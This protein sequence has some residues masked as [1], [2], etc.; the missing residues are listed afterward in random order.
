MI[1]RLRP[2]LDRLGRTG[3]RRPAVGVVAADADA[4][5]VALHDGAAAAATALQR[6]DVAEARRALAAI[7]QAVAAAETSD[8]RVR[9]AAALATRGHP[10]AAAAMLA[11]DRPT[12]ARAALAHAR[13]SAAGADGATACA[14][15]AEAFGRFPTPA[16]GVAYATALA[17]ELDYAGAFALLDR[18]IAADPR[19]SLRAARVRLLERVGALEEAAGAAAEEAAR[20]DADEGARAEAARLARDVGRFPAPAGE[21]MPTADERGWAASARREANALIAAGRLAEA[22]GLLREVMSRRGEANDGLA[23]VN[24]VLLGGEIEEGARLADEF[25]ARFPGDARFP[26][27]TAQLA[28]RRSDAVGMLEGYCRVLAADPRSAA[29]ATGVARAL[30]LGGRVRAARDWLQEADPAAGW[31]WTLL[32]LTEMRAGGQPAAEAALGRAYATGAA[33]L[34]DYRRG[35]AVS[36]NDCLLPDGRHIAHPCARMLAS[37]AL[38]DQ[39]VDDLARGGSAVLVGNSPR[40]LGQGRGA[41]IDAASTV[42]RLNDFRIRGFE[43]DVGARTDWWFSSA[44]RQAEPDRASVGAARSILTQ[45]MPQHAPEL[46]AFARGRLRLDLGPE[47]ACFLPPFLHALSDTLLYPGRTTGMRMILMLEF[48]LGGGFEAVGF[49]FF[50]SG[51]LHYFE[52]GADRLLVG[53]TH[54]PA[55]ERAFVEEVLVPLARFGRYS[56]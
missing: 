26:L 11:P 27:K 44:N 55:F 23:L 33:A 49:D 31:R 54:A 22:A 8:E 16:I 56:L 29:G 36:A 37:A 50:T 39:F 34:A 18:L 45:P 30:L 28:E 40:L 43:A 20:S 1:S 17:D 53:E 47:Q 32:A 52:N 48:V 7:P 25:A 9:L 19:K 3:G 2:L 15:W 12:S 14:L 42:I 41:R 13:A 21:A 4:L 51:S 46:P 38:F 24:A 35:R 6:E 5:A 10:G